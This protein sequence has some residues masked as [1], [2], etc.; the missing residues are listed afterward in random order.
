MMCSHRTKFPQLAR[1]NPVP[2]K[3]LNFWWE[4]SQCLVFHIKEPI[5]E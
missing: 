1:E 4:L 5:S 2:V 3:K